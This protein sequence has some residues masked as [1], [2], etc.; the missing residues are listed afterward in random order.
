MEFSLQRF[1]VSIEESLLRQFDDQ[2]AL[3][4]Y[5]TRSEAIRDLIRD[6][7]TKEVQKTGNALIVGTITFTYNHHLR[8]LSE[9]LTDLQHS[10]HQQIISALHV[11]LDAHNCM[12]VL[13]VKGTQSVV[14]EIANR[15]RSTKGIE[16]CHLT[17][18]LAESNS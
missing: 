16:I 10:Y 7:L 17:C 15:I 9:R 18:A 6:F 14:T 8:E 5:S 3:M 12:E 1:G 13:I 11:H 4:N 2:I